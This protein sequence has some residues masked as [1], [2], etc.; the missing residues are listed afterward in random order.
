MRIA[1]AAYPITWLTSWQEYEQK[2]D[3]WVADAAQNGA[4][5][6]VFPEYASMELSSL[7]GEES[8][9]KMETA[10][11]SVSDVFQRICDT[12]A[13]LSQR[14]KVHILSGSAPVWDAGRY[15]NRLGIFDPS[16]AYMLQ[17]KQIMTRFEREDWRVE[18]GNPLNVV[19][20][21]LGRFGVLICYDS[22]FPKLGRALKDVDVLLV[23]S[24]TEAM[25]GYW[26]V[27]IGAMARA[28]ENQCIAV[29]ASLLSTENRFNGVD[30]AIGT[31]GVFG[32]PDRGFPAD[33]VMALG[34]IGTPGWTYC[35]I[36]LN[37]IE[38]VRK[39]GVV[40]NRMHWC[41]QDMRD[42]SVPV[43]TVSDE[44]T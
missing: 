44:F 9:A 29:M 32:P 23:P 18:H 33:G 40:L 8:A 35:D 7:A 38:D 20:T 2:L 22:E 28:L 25:H 17:D 27:R 36:D 43:V 5:F 3:R 34:E 13:K 39:D 41:E 30:A 14:Y 4:N 37:A 31:G 42:L 24:C 19:E 16:G 15:V 11:A 26:R 6:L 10:L 1:T 12:Y 21:D